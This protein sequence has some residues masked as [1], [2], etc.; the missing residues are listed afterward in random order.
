M[1]GGETST[2]NN[3][4]EKKKTFVCEGGLSDAVLAY[5]LVLFSRLEVSTSALPNSF[6]LTFFG[7]HLGHYHFPGGARYIGDRRRQ[8]LK[9]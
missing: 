9:F 1:N 3:E 2:K 7:R 6:K 5:V 8:W 4:V